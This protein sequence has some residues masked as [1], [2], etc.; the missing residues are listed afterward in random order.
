[1]ADTIEQLKHEHEVRQE[2]DQQ[3]RHV[4]GAVLVIDVSV[5]L[6]VM[7]C[8]AAVLVAVLR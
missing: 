7:V 5:V 2:G 6:F 8:I 4:M 3:A 1:M